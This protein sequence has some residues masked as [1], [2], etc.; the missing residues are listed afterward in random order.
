MKFIKGN[1]YEI[2]SPLFTEEIFCLGENLKILESGILEVNEYFGYGIFWLSWIHDDEKRY[3]ENVEPLKSSHRRYK[4][5]P[6]KK[7]I[8]LST[9][10]IVDDGK[11]ELWPWL[12][13]NRQ[14][15]ID[16][17]KQTEENYKKFPWWKRVFIRI[18]MVS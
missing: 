12:K 7:K 5:S 16:L 8:L 1:L 4:I 9:F 14:Y 18:G 3:L 15:F 13:R 10:R 6:E 11:A 17:V 2:K